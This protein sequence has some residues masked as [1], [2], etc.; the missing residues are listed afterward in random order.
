MVL[1][2]ELQPEAES[3][4]M[5]FIGEAEAKQIH[6]PDDSEFLE[7]IK[8]VFVFSNFVY[9]NGVK[10]PDILAD[11]YTTGALFRGKKAAD[12]FEELGEY[13]DGV[14]D[15]DTLIKKLR[16]Y[17][18][19]EMIRIAIRDIAGYSDL[20]ETVSS[21]SDF[22][23]VCI[24]ISLDCLYRWFCERW[25]TPKSNNGVPQ[26]LV[27]IGMGKLGARELNFSSDIDL[28]FAFAENG[29]A[30]DP[31]KNISNT[32][33]F[34]N[35]CRT[36]IKV[37]GTNTPDGFVFRVDMRLRPYGESGPI[38]MS[39]G[40]LEEYYLVQGR[41]WERYAWI[42]ARVVAGDKV[43]GAKLMAVL[44]PFIYRKYL[45]YG[46]FESLREMK[47]KISRE[48]KT[49]ATRNDIKLGEGGIR[50]IEFFGQIFQLTRGGVESSL[51]TRRIIDVLTILTRDQYIP[52]HVSK[53]LSD[54]YTFLR[55]T[56]HRLQE[57]DDQQTHKLPATRGGKL[58]LA[59]SLG[60]ENITGYENEFHRH[61]RIV[62]SH[63]QKLLVTKD[64]E[65]DAPV[66]EKE[67][68]QVW[69]GDIPDDRSEDILRKIGFDE[70]A[71]AL[72][73]LIHLKK[74]PATRSLSSEG[75]KRL[76]KL[77]PLLLSEIGKAANP[78][79][80]LTRIIDLLIAIERRITY[81]SLLLENP[82]T[83]PHLVRLADSSSWIVGF[84]A[85]H[86]VLLDELLDPRTLYSPPRKDELVKELDR[87]ME[88]IPQD[89]LESQMEELRI[90]KQVNVLR[91]AAADITEG[92]PLMKVSDHLTDIAEAVL[93]K[94]FRIVWTHLVGK[95]G[96]PECKL[97]EKHC[98]VGFVVI[99][100]GKLGGFEL[101][102]GSD[103]DLV[104]LHAG[105]WGE[106]Q[107]GPKPIDN[108]T[109][110]AR[111]GQ[112]F[113]HLLSTRTP[114]GVLYEADMRL[115]P[116]GS[117]GV[118]VC[119]I[120]GYREY[121]LNEAWTWEKQAL[122]RARAVTGEAEMIERFKRIR[123]E[124]LG[125]PR[126][127]KSLR[128]EIQSMR[129][130]MQDELLG[131]DHPPEVFDLKQSPGGIVDIEFIVQYL[132]LLESHRFPELLIYPDNV[133]IL[134]YLK[135]TGLMD[136]VTAYFLRKA[137][138][139]F[140]TTAHR[141]DLQELPAVVPFER[142]RF[143]KERVEAAWRCYFENQ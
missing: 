26:K 119:H 74:E 94:V 111:V 129:K 59:A 124:S 122:V 66:I 36:L 32:E 101:G 108:I 24:D 100:Y 143:L 56:E 125:M 39:F 142:F 96:Q 140:R 68:G 45:D 91:V 7:M 141:L 31:Q 82:A 52:D 123:E 77:V 73:V 49:Q 48:I 53:E 62:H 6:L 138:L 27:V 80:A 55:N 60:F 5:E 28:I 47:E 78:L 8:K 20:S 25:G 10:K 139:I 99:A 103:L 1:P 9:R 136:E 81:L 40:A 37:L 105:G 17:R 135:E 113:L 137:Y 128:E 18:R 13:L 14:A 15:E 109:F 19:R 58:R 121:Q 127:E 54:A 133:R 34:T 23:D 64:G 76:D 117:A 87:R 69:R 63:F 42:K 112:R 95:H 3:K 70:P 90:F 102:Y 83:L 11:L 30:G 107:N 51:Q 61:T 110:F 41:E 67:V 71:E 4:W 134:Y 116:S 98:E 131:L 132:V 72:K 50:E 126:D 33:F 120:D 57:Y 38:V 79:T 89:D 88:S 92:L 114:A 86:P 43:S 75:R 93:A 65:S 104:F 44:N 97:D 22:A 2:A 29:R 84:L 115:R 85:R 35:L 118:L 46:V 16:E 21:L 130:R 12:Y 106:T